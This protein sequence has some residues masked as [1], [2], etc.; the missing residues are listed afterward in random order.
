MTLLIKILP[1]IMLSGFLTVITS[2]NGQNNI[3]TENKTPGT[4]PIG[5]TVSAPGRN[6]RGIFQ[7][8]QNILWF[9][10][11]GDGLFS[12]DGKTTRQFT[13]KNGLCGNFVRLIRP[14]K[15]GSVIISTGNGVCIFTGTQFIAVPSSAIK[16]NATDLT[17][18]VLLSG[19]YYRNNALYPFQ[20]PQ[21]SKLTKAYSQSPYSVYCS[22]KDSKGNIWFGTES[23][24][25][26]KYDGKTFTWLDNEE[27]GLAVRSLFEDRSGN[28]WIGNNGNGLFRYDGKDLINFTKEHKLE[29]PDFPTTLRGKE[30]TLARVWTITDDKKGVIWIGTIDAG[31]WKYD[32]KTLTNYTTK[33]GLV[34]NSILTVFCDK[35]GDLWIGTDNGISRYDGK[36]FSA[37]NGQKQNN[38]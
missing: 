3:S 8:D 5:D 33:D 29:N 4:G 32:G 35:A 28:I 22:L 15:D 34:S 1:S 11:D 31:L 13:E 30:G 25:V 7:D 12:Y 16:S 27:L 38:P 2:C 36:T 37:F 10:S 17:G 26:C 9:A 23:R 21:T 14:D 6:I 20:L 19:S 18:M 24:G